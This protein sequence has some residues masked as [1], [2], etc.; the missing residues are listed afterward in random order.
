M[1]RN[2]DSSS[3]DCR[4][5][6]WYEKLSGVKC[7]VCRI[8]PQ[9][10]VGRTPIKSVRVGRSLQPLFSNSSSFGGQ[11]EGRADEAA[12]MFVLFTVK[13]YSSKRRK[14]SKEAAVQ[15]SMHTALRSVT[16]AVVQRVRRSACSTDV[17]VT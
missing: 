4:V 8:R 3:R 14:S 12:R 11:I 16:R 17:D 2:C 5:R 6:T 7:R 13:S 9:A 1:R 10:A 15:D